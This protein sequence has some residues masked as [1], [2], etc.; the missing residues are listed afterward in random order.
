[1][2]MPGRPR[3][4][5]IDGYALIYR[6]FHA[7]GGSGPLRNARGENTG[8]A[9]GVSDFL[10]RL[11][12]KHRP[13]YLGWVNDAGSSGREEMLELYKANRVALPDE[14]QEDFDTGVERVM[15]ILKG[16]RIPMLA[17]DGFEADD[18]IATLALQGAAQDLEVCVVSGDKDL[19]QLVRPRIYVLNPW[20]GPP[21]RT[22]EKWYGIENAHERLGVP[23]E[24]VVDY[25]ALV[26]DKADN[27]PGVKGIGD[28]GALALV[29]KYK[30]VE[31]MLEHLD[32][33]EPTRLR[34]A[35]TNER[36][37]ALLSKRLVTLQYDLPISLDL[38]SLTLQT[39]DWARLRDLFIELEFNSAARAAA[40]QMESAS[41]VTG[42]SDAAGD[43]D[44]V[45]EAGAGGLTRRE[46]AGRAADARATVPGTPAAVATTYRVADTPALVAEVIAEARSAGSIAV[47]TETI[48]DVGAPP[49]ITPMRANLVAISI[50][51][52][53]GRAWYLPFA[54]RVPSEAQGGLALD[55]TPAPP[56][57]TKA[58][59]VPAA[60]TSIAARLLAEGAH[61]VVNLPPLLSDAMA[62]LRELLE[63][64]AVHKT[65]H[66]AKYDQLVLRRAGVTL[67]GLDFDSMLASYVL[68][69][70]RRSHAI[71]A[72]SVEFLGIAMTGFEELCGKGRQQVPY[73]EVPI[74]AARDYSC[75]DSD[76]ALRL[77][78][79]LEPR[80]AEHQVGA[81]LRDVELP[82]VEVLAEMEWTGITIDLPWFHSLKTRF[83]AA[84]RDIETQIHA[85][86]GEEF[87]VASNQQLRVVLFE[88]LGL[89]VKKK[90]ATGPS[91]DASVLME[92]AE[93]GH[94]LPNLLMEYRELAKLENTYLDT[95]P[96]LVNPGTGRLHTS[97]NQTVASTG[98]LSSS[99]P[100][101]Q[102]IP[103]RRELG[104]DIRRGFIPREGWTLMAADYSQIELRLLAHLSHDPAF[105]DAFRAGGDIHRQTAGII[106]GV[107]V[108]TVSAEMRARAKTINFATIYGQGAHALSRQLKVEHA[109]AKAFIETYFERFAGV[110]QWL[111]GSVAQAR[112]RGYVET[113]FHRRRYIPE[114]HDRNFNTRSF[115]ER[116][117]QNSPIQGSAADLIK[118]AMIRIHH[119]L[120][121]QGMQS[122]MLL[123]VHDE[124]VFECPSD[125][126]ERLREVVEREMTTAI[127]LD[128]PLVV[129]VGT[130]ANWL[131]AKG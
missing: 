94:E 73:D 118:V 46:A 115:G 74:V 6:S 31:A 32:E 70:S 60:A 8:M 33:I 58:K 55:D 12:E 17:L 130:G 106:F 42:A 56:K 71:D 4:Y 57:K 45:G 53:P 114:I 50:A 107:P 76:I 90:T 126:L 36:E 120:L 11:I 68:D 23:A 101:L 62:P 103:I 37:M 52:A 1:M 28:K 85:A 100:N 84:R 43:G 127:A 87:N 88:K 20:H 97:F 75:A 125:E 63:D 19:L 83:E 3:L 30:T 86:A 25:L 110:R 111:D 96:L 38:P 18:V 79:L 5:L 72:L 26:G 121:N 64:P 48:L 105:V 92:L 35:L 21:G 124:L 65:A 49:L 44:G 109:E 129:D 81:L 78:A 41:G 98:R 89:P 69:P 61:P 80:L 24:C 95:L 29:Q 14:E 112:E 22:T 10:K 99:D 93:E 117:A 13:D 67:R 15:E 82:L 7:L 116:L 40:V 51:T 54:H 2:T 77:R 131:E 122:R 113:I 108:E 66:N 102:N 16:Y 9:K 47:D 123:Q 128:V 59:Q 104:K 119:A 34:N 27:V 39:P 91:T